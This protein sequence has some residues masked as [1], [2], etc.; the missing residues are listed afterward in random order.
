MTLIT[1]LAALVPEGHIA[2][3][4]PRAKIAVPLGILIFLGSIFVLLRSNLGGRRGYLV[5]S[6][7]LWGFSTVLSAIW[8]FGAPGTPAGGGP[9]RLPGQAIDEYEPQWVAPA[10][11]STLGTDPRLDIVQQYPQGFQPVPEDFRARAV[12]GADEIKN[13]FSGFDDTSPYSNVIESTWAPLTDRVGFAMSEDPRGFPI[14]AVPYVPT[15]Q[16]APLPEDAPEG[17]APV[18]TVDGESPAPDGSNVAPPGTEVGAPVVGAEPV[19]LFGYFDRGNPLF[20][21]YVV[22]AIIV[23]LFLLH[24]AL[25]ARDERREARERAAASATAEEDRTPVPV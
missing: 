4:D 24:I 23:V 20:P 19:V 25:L 8:A 22:F 2:P 12:N 16:L 9:L 1:V 7:S 14:I 13:F 11:D 17:T 18:L 6:V 5:L 15:Y 21:S 3:S 10:Q